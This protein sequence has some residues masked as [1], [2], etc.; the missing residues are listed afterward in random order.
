MGWLVAAGVADRV[1]T[2][3]LRFKFRVTVSP[4]TGL[5]LAFIMAFM[6]MNKTNIR[7]VNAVPIHSKSGPGDPNRAAKKFEFSAKLSK[8]ATKWPTNGHK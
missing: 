3:P 4:C 2:I 7:V 8:N 1:T 6:A 5:L